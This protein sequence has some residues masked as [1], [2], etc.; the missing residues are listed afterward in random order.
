MLYH[1]YSDIK[2]ILKGTNAANI[3]KDFK[4]G[5]LVKL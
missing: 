5:A 4:L 1:A 2:A 3:R